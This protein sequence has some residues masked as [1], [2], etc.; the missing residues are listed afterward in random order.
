MKTLLQLMLGLALCSGITSCKK[1]LQEVVPQD[2]IS[3]SEALTNAGAAQTLYT[4]VYAELRTYTGVLFQLGEMRSEIWTDGIYTESADPT[5]A[6]L[7]DQNIGALNVPE[8]NWAGFYNLIYQINNVIYVFPQCPLP[9]AQRTQELAEMYGLRAYIY[10]AMLQTWG[11]VPLITAPI[12]TVGNAAQTY[13]PRS[14][15]DSVMLQIKSDINQSL[16]LYNGSNTV[17]S[18]THAYWNRLCTLILE[19][20]VYDWSGTTL[21]GG[22]T[23]NPADLTTAETALQQVENLQSASLEL[24]PTYSDI[25][26]ST[27]KSNNPEIIFALNFELNQAQNTYFSEFL[28]NSSNGLGYLVAPNAGAQVVVGSSGLYPY[29]AGS[30]RIGM[31]QAM[32]TKLTADSTDQRIGSTFQFMYSKTAPYPLVGMMLKKY[33]G[34]V[35]GTSQLYNNDYP[36]YRYADVL[37]LLAEVKN[38]LGQDPSPEI[39]L[40]RQRAH[41]A[42]Y[43]PYVNSGGNANTLAI[44]EE[45]L[46]EYIGE[47]KR[48]FGLRR[49]GDQWV[50]NYVNSKYLNAGTVA[51]ATGPNFLLPISVS[52]LNNDPT[53]VQTPGY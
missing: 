15:P 27:K 33:I 10:Y 24:N 7:Y 17:V 53:L 38:K 50:Y 21:G 8:A 16:T 30:D 1:Q 13:T 26:N 36:I 18:G 52:M 23:A 51:S 47:G 6:N 29:V 49:A 37:L 34:V 5:Y 19:G 25:F 42:S 31:N 4:G 45:E 22:T 20:D 9:V 32:V 11:G 2:Q 46:R 41:G 44:L 14:T 35:N 40:I 12:T 3:L 39:N 43:V 48:W 28:V